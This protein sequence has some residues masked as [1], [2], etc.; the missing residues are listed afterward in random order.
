TKLM[1]YDKHDCIQAE[2][3]QEGDPFPDSLPI[4]PFLQ[5][6]GK[7]M[8]R[9][10]GNHPPG[11]GK[12]DPHLS[13][14]FQRDLTAVGQPLRFQVIFLCMHHSAAY[15]SSTSFQCASPPAIQHALAYQYIRQA[16]L[17]SIRNAYK[18]RSLPQSPYGVLKS[19]H[20]TPLTISSRLARR[21]NYSHS[22]LQLLKYA[23]Y[24]APVARE[25]LLG[26][27]CGYD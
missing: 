6:G 17:M 26:F 1:N 15:P 11:R 7:L 24:D 21:T 3:Q 2:Y 10:R 4:N 19:G 16:L 14:V 25:Q 9:I 5:P 23:V 22:R 27:Q 13:K 18:A 12:I 8:N 20:G